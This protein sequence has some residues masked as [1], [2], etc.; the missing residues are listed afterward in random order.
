[1]F[2]VM[3]TTPS[4][5]QSPPGIRSAFFCLLALCLSGF[6]T[7]QSSPAAAKPQSPTFLALTNFDSF[8]LST[9][10][11]GERVLLSDWLTNGFAWDELIVSWNATAPLG[12]GLKIETRA[13]LGE[14]ATKF[15]VMGLW[16]EDTAE[17]RRESVNE[18]KDDDGDVLTDTLR[19]NRTTTRCQLQL[20][21]LPNARG[22]VPS[23][24]RLG[25][26]LVDRAAIPAPT[27]AFKTAWGNTL[28]VPERSQLSYSG[29]RDWCSPTSVSMVLAYWAKRLN[30]PA[31]DIDVPE[32]AVGVFDPTWPGTGNWPFNTAF[33]GQQPG[34]RASVMRFADVAEIEA[35]VAAG[36]PVVLSISYQ[37]LYNR[38]SSASNGHLVVCI[39]FTEKGDAVINDPWADFEKGDKVRA[40]IPRANLIK[41]WAHSKRTAYVIYPE[42]WPMPAS[43]AGWW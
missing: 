19:L 15:Y 43:R 2:R 24:R 3:A 20:T 42:S 36:V 12:S 35:L 38:P 6:A 22:D 8:K 26:S 34:L 41:A 9:N 1:M 28:P 32:V 25:L 4:P 10:A 16:T 30:Q 14:R 18:Q 23:V 33:A 7:P 29:G 31:L 27:P 40:V 17:R 11:A 13:K 5:A 21:L 37:L 39:G